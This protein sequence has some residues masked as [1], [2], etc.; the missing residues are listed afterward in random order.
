MSN[1]AKSFLVVN[2]SAILLA[3]LSSRATALRLSTLQPVTEN[4]P[5]LKVFNAVRVSGNKPTLFRPLQRAQSPPFSPPVGPQLSTLAFPVPTIP[6]EAFEPT[7]PVSGYFYPLYALNLLPLK[8]EA[9]MY[10]AL[11]DKDKKNYAM[12]LRKFIEK[13]HELNKTAE[14][15]FPEGV[16]SKI[17]SVDEWTPQ[18]IY[19]DPVLAKFIFDNLEII[20]LTVQESD[21]NGRNTEGRMSNCAYFAENGESEETRTLAKDTMT[22]AEKIEEMLLDECEVGDMKKVDGPKPER[23]WLRENNVK[24]RIWQAQTDDSAAATVKFNA[25]RFASIV[26]VYAGDLKRKFR[27]EARAR[28]DNVTEM[29]RKLTK[30]RTRVIRAYEKIVQ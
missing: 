17:E 30:Y 21:W 12:N 8:G 29:D 20:K 27:M 16:L 11:S 9:A 15:S 19:E 24:L 5:K 14:N 13:I 6:A 4:I 22:F 23:S 28:F 1:F 25:E 26:E 3:C 10:D 2:F 18:T 7:K